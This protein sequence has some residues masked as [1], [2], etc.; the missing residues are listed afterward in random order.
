MYEVLYV[1]GISVEPYCV[2][3]LRHRQVQGTQGS[4]A[5]KRKVSPVG[6]AYLWRCGSNVWYGGI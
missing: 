5:Y 4:K 1:I 2:F 6:G 3:H